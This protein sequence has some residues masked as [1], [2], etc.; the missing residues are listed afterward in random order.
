MFETANYLE[1]ALWTI[2]ALVFLIRGLR[3]RGRERGISFAL[4]AAFLLFGLSDVVETHTG[5]WWRP[6]WLFAWKAACL[7]AILVLLLSQIQRRAA[8]FIVLAIA[9]GIASG[10]SLDRAARGRIKAVAAVLNEDGTITTHEHPHNVRHAR[11]WTLLSLTAAAASVGCLTAGVVVLAKQ[12][13]ST[14]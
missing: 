10:L 12:R 4:V 13:K 14:A 7:A 5:A 3:R 8:V 1:A 11:R 2:G 9:F 6:W